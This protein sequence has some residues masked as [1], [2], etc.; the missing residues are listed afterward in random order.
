VR[1]A[2]YAVKFDTYYLLENTIST[3]NT[4]RQKTVR[5]SSKKYASPFL[6]VFLLFSIRDTFI[7]VRAYTTPASTPLH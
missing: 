1:H 5:Q 4:I 2:V 6:R 7:N 3:F